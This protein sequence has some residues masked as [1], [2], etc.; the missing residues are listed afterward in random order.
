VKLQDPSLGQLT[1]LAWPAGASCSAQLSSALVYFPPSDAHATLSQKPPGV[2]VPMASRAC[3]LPPARRHA[4]RHAL[5]LPAASA[6]PPCV[7]Q[8]ASR[9]RSH[10]HL[11]CAAA[12]LHSTE[13]RRGLEFSST[14]SADRPPALCR[15]SS[16]APRVVSSYLGKQPLDC[17][18]LR[19][20]SLL[21]VTKSK[22]DP[23][24][25]RFC[26]ARFGLTLYTYW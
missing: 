2:P 1:L 8:P 14:S 16:G 20:L 9:R 10:A 23:Y 19:D 26:C 24:V 3:G 21:P 13:A 5:L 17:Y 18:G 7:S 25:V 11:A 15:T 12:G 4:G 22:S 6:A